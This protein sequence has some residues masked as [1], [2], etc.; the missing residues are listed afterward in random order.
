[1]NK[2]S[3]REA[4]PP[5]TASACLRSW[6]RCSQYSAMIPASATAAT[7]SARA[8]KLRLVEGERSTRSLRRLEPFVEHGEC[9]DGVDQP[10]G[11]PHDQ[12]GEPLVVDRVEPDAGHAH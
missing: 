7:I 12:S 6:L 10:A 4:S 1:M 5:V 3:P 9:R 2:A 11:D 8:A